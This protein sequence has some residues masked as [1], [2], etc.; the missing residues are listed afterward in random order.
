MRR[1][2]PLYPGFVALLVLTCVPA[3]RALVPADDDLG[4]SGFWF[5]MVGAL[6]GAVLTMVAW[7]LSAVALVP[8][9]VAVVVVVAGAA[10]T[11][12]R[13]DSGVATLVRQENDDPWEHEGITFASVVAVVALLMLRAACLIGTDVE[14][15]PAAL[16]LSHA[17]A[18]WVVLLLLKLGDQL[19]ADEHGWF[20]LTIGE[21]SW[22]LFGAAS[23]VIAIL[24]M[25]LAGG[26]GMIAML[27]AAALAF[28]VG[29]F[30][31]RRAGGLGHESLAA[32][33]ALCEVTVLLVF[34]AVH[35]PAL[36]PWIG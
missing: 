3:P 21:L 1:L 8:A 32:A 29:L 33:A 22:K 5:P 16:I 17:I 14:H 24:V 18:G 36:S 25:L 11:A 26:T 13:A 10:L 12:G 31:Q 19:P 2:G 6:V 28:V 9:V 30:F 4:R 27:I 15:W 23:A 20:S 7:L 34:A 35:Q